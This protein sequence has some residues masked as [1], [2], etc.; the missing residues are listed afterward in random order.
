MAP[1]LVYVATDEPDK[2]GFFQP[3][4]D[5]GYTLKFLDDYFEEA[6]LA[7]LEGNLMGA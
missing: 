2:A 5:A 7:G 3:L 1:Q 4:R 6:G